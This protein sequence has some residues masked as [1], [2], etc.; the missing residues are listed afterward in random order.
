ML[1]SETHYE[2]SGIGEKKAADAGENQRSL[3]N[4]LNFHFVRFLYRYDI[5]IQW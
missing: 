1:P 4:L 3:L 5:V 2:G